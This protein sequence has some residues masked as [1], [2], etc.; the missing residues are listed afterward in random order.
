M[1]ASS[2]ISSPRAMRVRAE[3]SPAAKRR[4][5]S[6]ISR[7]GP[8]RGAERSTASSTATTNATARARATDRATSCACSSIPNR[9]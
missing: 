2:P 5:D 7:K 4:A 8:A 3:R 6:I 9:G 1:R